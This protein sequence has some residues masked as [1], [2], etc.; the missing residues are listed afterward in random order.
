MQPTATRAAT[1]SSDLPTEPDSN[2]RIVDDILRDLLAAV[3]EQGS[4]ARLTVDVFDTVLTRRYLA[5]GDIFHETAERA[6]TEGA[7]D[8]RLAGSF[9]ADRVE[10]ERLAERTH[11]ISCATLAEIYTCYAER[12]GLESASAG[13]LCALEIEAELA[14]AVPIPA[15]IELLAACRSHGARIAFVSDMY[16]DAQTIRRLLD[17]IGA[18]HA[19]SEIVVSCEHRRRKADGGLFA[20][21][22]LS[23][24][25][26]FLHL[27][28]SP[29]RDGDGARR[30]GGTP[31]SVNPAHP[32]R[33][34]QQLASCVRQGPVALRQLAGV[35]RAARIGAPMSRDRRAQVINETAANLAG[36]LALA[37]AAWTLERAQQRG[38]RRLYFAAREGEILL[39]VARELERVWQTG[40]DLRYLCVSRNTL[41]LPACSAC[42]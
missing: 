35:S 41:M 15:V 19:E 9:P 10:A 42:T 6:L 33:Y 16:L 39:S 3:R 22:N 34:E 25:P 32:T 28:D 17:R 29:E 7:L 30:A 37:Y 1:C 14:A 24:E 4:A 20:C 5:P 26:G 27:G 36:P 11:G 31:Y 8:R 18:G 40:I 21:C 13:R 2:G 38:L 23:R 12:A